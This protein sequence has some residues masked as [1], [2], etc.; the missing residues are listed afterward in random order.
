MPM[1]EKKSKGMEGITQRGRVV[2]MPSVAQADMII[3]MVA[4]A[5]TV[6]GGVRHTATDNKQVG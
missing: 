6:Q 2:T 4:T 5:I 3:P 1:T